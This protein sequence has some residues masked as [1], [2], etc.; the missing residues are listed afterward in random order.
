MKF[1]L[2]NRIKLYYIVA[3]VSSNGTLTFISQV[4]LLL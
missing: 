1:V 4:F 2:L 3:C